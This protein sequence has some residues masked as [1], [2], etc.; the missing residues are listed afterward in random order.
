MIREHFNR[1]SNRRGNRITDNRVAV[2]IYISTSREL[3]EQTTNAILIPSTSPTAG[4]SFLIGYLWG[5]LI[6]LLFDYLAISTTTTVLVSSFVIGLLIY[7]PLMHF[8][9]RLLDGKNN[10]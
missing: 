5:T 9:S 4:T 2:A 6:R 8:D 10:Q 7:R 3:Q 1:H